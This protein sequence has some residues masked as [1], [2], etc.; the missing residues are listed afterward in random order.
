MVPQPRAS[1]KT[2]PRLSHPH[3]KLPSN[4]TSNQNLGV[5]LKGPALLEH[6]DLDITCFSYICS[7]SQA[8]AHT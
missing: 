4:L 7:V 2:D 5:S 1:L 8:S 6:W 3:P